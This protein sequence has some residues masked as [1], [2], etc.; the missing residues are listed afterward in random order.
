MRQGAETNRGH[1]HFV[2]RLSPT[3]VAVTLVHRVLAGAEDVAPPY[4]GRFSFATA[5][6][7][8]EITPIDDT[9][10]AGNLTNLSAEY[11]QPD[12]SA[13]VI[14]ENF[15][16]ILYKEHHV[17][18][19]TPRAWLFY[20][21]AVF[22]QATPLPLVEKQC[23]SATLGTC[24]IVLRATNPQ[25]EWSRFNSGKDPNVSAATNSL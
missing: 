4:E 8:L 20:D 16:S 15:I 25:D 24:H 13:Q 11:H 5:P 23:S 17:V 22:C 21:V 6:Y 9:K 14:S 12:L 2:R 19:F 7:G 1:T 3:R 18:S 10:M